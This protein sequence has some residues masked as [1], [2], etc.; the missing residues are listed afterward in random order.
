M[1][2]WTDRKF[3]IKAFLM[4]LEIQDSVTAYGI[5]GRYRGQNSCQQIGARSNA[6]KSLFRGIQFMLPFVY[7]F[8]GGC[9]NNESN[10]NNYPLHTQIYGTTY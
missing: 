2:H 7:N 9:P 8:L 10:V 4:Q 5:G 6:S 3:G 1:G